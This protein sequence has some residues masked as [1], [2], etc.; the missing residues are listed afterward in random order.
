M[1]KKF[2]GR[3]FSGSSLNCI[4][5][6]LFRHFIR[7][8]IQM[9]I[10][11]IHDKEFFGANEILKS[12][13]KKHLEEGGMKK[14]FEAIE[15]HDL[16]RLRDYFNRSSPERLQEEVYFVLEYYMGLRGREWIRHLHRKCIT[17][18]TDSKGNEYVSLN[19]S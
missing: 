7:P 11:I 15:D 13:A 18:G 8:P 14:C 10:D 4:R 1:Y 19:R 6:A 3:Y 2:L 16:K 17:F 5:A 12:M 9:N